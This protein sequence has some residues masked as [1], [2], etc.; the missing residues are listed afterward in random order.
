MDESGAGWW[1]VGVE[2]WRV[3]VDLCGILWPALARMEERRRIEAPE[4]VAEAFANED[5]H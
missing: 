2:G 4:I 1:P 5:L 3:V